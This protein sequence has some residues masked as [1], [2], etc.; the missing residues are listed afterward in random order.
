MDG[1]MGGYKMAAKLSC[2]AVSMVSIYTKEAP[3][4]PT[5]VDSWLPA[6]RWTLTQLA[7][8]FCSPITSQVSII[9][10]RFYHV[11]SQLILFSKV[12]IWFN[13]KI[14]FNYIFACV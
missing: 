9:V 14:E 5:L 1:W 7:L 3:R 6:A 8:L 4:K 13:A 10:G 11:L 12:R 2:L